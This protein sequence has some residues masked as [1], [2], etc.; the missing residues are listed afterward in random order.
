MRFPELQAYA[1]AKAK[2]VPRLQPE[3][4]D[5]VALA[6]DEIADGGSE[7]HECELARH[8]IDELISKEAKNADR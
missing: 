3:I 1:R 2:T 6:E 8:D 7:E 5:L 4:A